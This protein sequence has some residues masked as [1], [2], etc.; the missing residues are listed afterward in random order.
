MEYTVGVDAS[1]ELFNK[2]IQNVPEK[3]KT[4]ND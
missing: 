4:W 1:F 3:T 2:H